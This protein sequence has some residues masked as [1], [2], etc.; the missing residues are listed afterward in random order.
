MKPIASTALAAVVSCAALGLIASHALADPRI[1]TVTY[2]PDTVIRLNGCFGYQTLIQFGPGEAV[3]NVGIG[4]AAQWLVTPNK[5]GDLLFVKPAYRTTRGNMTVSTNRRTYAFELSAEASARC[6]Q[7]DV[8]YTLRFAYPQDAV[9]AALAA[10]TPALSAP[11][12]PAEPSPAARN[13][14][15]TF[16]GARENVPVRVF[17]DGRSTWFRW[18]EGATTPAVYAVA[19]DHTE[20]AVAFTSQG[21]WLVAPVVAPTFVLRR[22]NAVATLFND[23]YQTPALDA[24]S[25]QPRQAETTQSRPWLARAFSRSAPDVR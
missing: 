22:G 23:A 17:D 13:L 19:T 10:E 18:S 12:A 1:Q 25:P 15:Y 3:E 9:E 24:G 8:V 5:R 6:A 4:D 16:S 2:D 21:D 11:I 14:A 20:S 7:G